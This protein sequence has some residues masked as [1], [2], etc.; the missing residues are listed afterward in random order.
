M[1]DRTINLWVLV[2][3]TMWTLLWTTVAVSE[4]RHK[5]K[6]Y[7]LRRQ[8]A[9]QVQG[10]PT[11]RLYIGGRTIDIYRNGQ[12]FEGDALVGVRKGK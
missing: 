11:S 8:E 4:P 3:C 12:M 6:N 7:I 2:A 10:V 1:S 5:S 9:Y